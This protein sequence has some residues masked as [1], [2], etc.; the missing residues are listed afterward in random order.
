M[1]LLFV[2][3]ITSHYIKFKVKNAIALQTLANTIAI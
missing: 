1:H 3:N 2:K